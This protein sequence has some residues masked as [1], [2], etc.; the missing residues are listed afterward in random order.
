M[1]DF[2]VHAR[3]RREDRRIVRLGCEV[4]RTSDWSLVGRRAIDLSP[5]GAQVL[6]ERDEGLVPGEGVQV[7]FRIPFENI[8]VLAE[9]EVVRVVRGKRRRDEGYGFGLRFGELHPG[10][11]AALHASMCRFPPTLPHRPRRV[12]YAATVRRIGLD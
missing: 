6:A 12:D 1:E 2:I 10:A 11:R 8:W 3:D 9:A 7:F 4:V 5:Q